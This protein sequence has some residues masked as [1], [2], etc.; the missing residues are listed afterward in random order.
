M[1]LA[2]FDPAGG[3]QIATCDIAR[4][5]SLVN[6]LFGSNLHE[7]FPRTDVPT[8]WE[9][10]P[11]LQALQ[12]LQ[13]QVGN[14]PDPASFPGLFG[15][16]PK[17]QDIHDRAESDID[18]EDLKRIQ[19]RQSYTRNDQPWLRFSFETPLP[20][21]EQT[22]TGEPDP[23]YAQLEAELDAILAFVQ[24]AIAAP[25][26]ALA[27]VPSAPAPALAP[28]STDTSAPKP[29]PAP[30]QPAAPPI[31]DQP[32]TPTPDQPAPETDNG[33]DQTPGA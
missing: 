31:P 16:E 33:T 6:E 27:V 30:E 17:P 23:R 12:A 14:P 9:P 18:P 11:T 15:T 2:L 29:A 5:A 26:S 7:L 13:E 25:G 21:G 32:A 22:T 3:G 4:A 8:A 10:E 1:N 24:K 20:T 19:W 28:T